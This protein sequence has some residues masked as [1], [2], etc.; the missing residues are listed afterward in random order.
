MDRTKIHQRLALLTQAA[1]VLNVV[2]GFV[3]IP[4]TDPAGIIVLVTLTAASAF[5]IGLI[6]L[7]KHEV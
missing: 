6:Q 7:F 5:G 1:A 2:V 4:T 3:V